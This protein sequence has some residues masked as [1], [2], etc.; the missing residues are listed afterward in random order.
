[1]A[2]RTVK[3]ASSAGLHARPAARFVAAASGTGLDVGIAR[4]GQEA[5]DATSVLAVM[6]LG[7]GTGEQVELTAD[8]EGA[9][10][11]LD[12][13]VTLLSRDLDAT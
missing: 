5:V 12:A 6:T 4:P 8:G 3:I 2:R 11:A 9:E 1:V 13:L 10:E 7:A